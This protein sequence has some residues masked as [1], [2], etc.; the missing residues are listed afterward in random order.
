MNYF[1][2]GNNFKNPLKQDTLLLGKSIH[3]KS[4]CSMSLSSQNFSIVMLSTVILFCTYF[5]KGYFPLA[6][7]KLLAPI[8][9]SSCGDS[10]NSGLIE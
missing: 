9:P 4:I 2:F 8:F 7:N 6:L 3:T 1:T 5:S 10:V